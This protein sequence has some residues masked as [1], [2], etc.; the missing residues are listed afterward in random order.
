MTT[1]NHI[2]YNET[3]LNGKFQV[4]SNFELAIAGIKKY[5]SNNIILHK[6]EIY[7]GLNNYWVSKSMLKSIKDQFNPERTCF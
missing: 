3:E 1:T 7:K 6:N 2:F 4:M 5:G